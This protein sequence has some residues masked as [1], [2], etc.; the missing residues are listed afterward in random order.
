VNGTT[1]CVPNTTPGFAPPSKQSSICN[2]I[3]TTG[4][5]V[6]TAMILKYPREVA[7]AYN[8]NI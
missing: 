5:T 3:N 4:T 8:P 6:A 7:Y 2:R 1:W